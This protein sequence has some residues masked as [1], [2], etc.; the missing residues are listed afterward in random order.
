VFATVS[1]YPKKFVTDA[2]TPSLKPYP[3][4]VIPDGYERAVD[5]DSNGWPQTARDRALQVIRKAFAFHIAGD[6]HLG[7]TIQYGIDDWHDAGYAVC[8]PSI[9]NTWPRRW[10]PERPG[11]NYEESDPKYTGDYRDG[12][13]NLV[14]VLA[15]SNPII[16]NHEPANLHDRAPGYGIVRF[17]KKSR[18]IEIEVWPRW[19][20]PSKPGAKQYPGWPITI[21]QMD[22]FGQSAKY[23][24]PNLNISGLTDPVVQVINENTGD[25]VY[26]VRIKGHTFTPRVLKSGSYSINVGELNTAKQKNLK[27]IVALSSKSKK[28]IQID[29]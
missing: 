10:Y 9:G 21:N 17:K 12:F 15:V 3:V 29:F 6:Q 19:E 2:G 4:G 24:L 22:N 7:T 26:T 8:V 20:D 1:T 28:E 25:I 5:M 14:S 11:L 16:S 23:Y 27:N 18:D 13:G